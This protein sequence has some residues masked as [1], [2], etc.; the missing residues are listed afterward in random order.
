MERDELTARA[1]AA[2]LRLA[3]LVR[4]LDA[5]EAASPVPGAEWTAIETAAHVVNLYG[6][7]LG[8]RRRSASAAETAALNAVCLDEYD[9]RDPGI[10]AE[11]ITADAV[12]VWDGLFPLVPEDAEIVFHAGAVTTIQ[13]IMGVLLLEMLVHGDDIARAT[14]RAWVVGDDDAWCALRACSPLLPAWRRADVP[15]ADT[16][17]IVG[18]DRDAVRIACDGPATTVLHGP[19]RPGE[20][21]VDGPPSVALLGLLG[22]RPAT[23]ALADLAARFGPF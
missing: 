7:A 10:V 5:G 18:P 12:Q 22:R 20:R 1:R 6:R 16:I 8:D 13:P 11:R 23:G 2:S 3:D 19:P 4:S 15:A 17:A 14:G 21:V 9:E